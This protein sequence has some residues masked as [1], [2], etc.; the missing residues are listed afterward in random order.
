MVEDGATDQVREIVE[1]FREHLDIVFLQQSQS[2]PASARNAGAKRARGNYLAFLD[3][4]CTVTQ[5]WLE[6]LESSLHKYP[7]ALLGG[8]T[9]NA[10][11]DN[12]FSRASQLI[13]DF[14]Y[15][16]FRNELADLR[17]FTSNN[18]VIP[19]EGF[20]ALG[21]F[22]DRHFHLPAA[23]D[24]DLC[25]R[26]LSYGGEMVYDPDLRVLHF[27]SLTLSSF[28]AQHF[29][30]GRGAW[31]YWQVRGSLGGLKRPGKLSFHFKL[32]T[33]PWR[34]FNSLEAAIQS[35]LVVLS[36]LSYLT[37]YL[38]ESAKNRF[39]ARSA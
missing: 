9:L 32:I 26:W 33:C 8:R 25:G 14:L 29:R 6:H 36:Q 38:V 34:R 7:R 22:D 3:D 17:F 18:L 2:G 39:A 19:A 11:E 30:Y 23:E 1:P 12:P 10:L 24:R 13:I 27:H 5:S 37:G 31:H 28:L 4:D 20:R 21:G 16:A 35:A 15:G